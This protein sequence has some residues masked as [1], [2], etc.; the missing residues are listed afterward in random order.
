MQQYGLVQELSSVII[1]GPR[2]RDPKRLKSFVLR[3]KEISNC[4]SRSWPHANAYIIWREMQVEVCF[5]PQCQSKPVSPMTPIRTQKFRWGE[6]GH[7]ETGPQ[8]AELQVATRQGW[9]AHLWSPKFRIMY[10]S[11]FP[12]KDGRW[13]ADYLWSFIWKWECLNNKRCLWYYI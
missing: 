3:R 12:W 2:L 7:S 4:I 1:L 8:G 11:W 10:D 5:T 13:F 9:E 6:A